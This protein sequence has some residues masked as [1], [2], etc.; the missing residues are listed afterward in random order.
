VQRR[1]ETALALPE[2]TGLRKRAKTCV[3]FSLSSG[4]VP[5]GVVSIDKAYLVSAAFNPE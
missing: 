5:S 4:H 2:R 3:F 1:G